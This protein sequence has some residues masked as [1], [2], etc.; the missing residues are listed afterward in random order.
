M[1]SP[2]PVTVLTGFLGAGKTT[3]LN[4]LLSRRHGWKVAVIENEFGEVGVDH[5]LVLTAEEDL[6]LL[7]NGCVCCKIRGD[8][9]RT[10]HAILRRPERF[11]A[12]LVETTGLADPGPVLQSFFVDEDLKERLRL[13]AVVTVVDARHTEP[14]LEES[15]EARRQVAFADVLLLNKTDLVGADALRT[16]ERR[17]RAINPLARLH[18]TVRAQIEPDKILGLGAFDLSR[19]PALPPEDEASHGRHDPEI[20]AVCLR[21]PGALDG[22]ALNAWLGGLLR[23][24]GADLFRMKGIVQVA[25]EPRRVVF[26]GVHMM[27][28]GRPDRPWKPGEDRTNRLVFIGRRLDETELRE[29]LRACVHRPSAG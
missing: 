1:T 27:F 4:H 11:D 28:E 23:S 18:R 13:D 12:I 15:P 7:N 2:V 14:H 8:L 6:I 22:R 16:L 20:R 10:L 5:D 21:E 29:G 25:G 26:Q 24:R 19:A 9:V 3:L 17:L